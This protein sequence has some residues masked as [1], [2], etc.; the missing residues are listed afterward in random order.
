MTRV[1]NL[2]SL[3]LAVALAV[4]LFISSRPTAPDVSH[5]DVESGA[6]DVVAVGGPPSRSML[7]TVD[8]GGRGE[9][10]PSIASAPTEQAAAGV[11]LG[12]ADLGPDFV[13]ATSG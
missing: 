12:P 9:L 11:V 7:R 6:P 3:G 1:R 2:S 8:L 5:A 4:F 13:V 10:S